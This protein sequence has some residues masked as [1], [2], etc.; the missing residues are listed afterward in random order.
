M[1][2][3]LKLQLA[4]LCS[5]NQLLAILASVILTLTP[6][7]EKVKRSPLAVV[8]GSP[9][10]FGGTVTVVGNV[11][12]AGNTTASMT[13]SGTHPVIVVGAIFQDAAITISSATWSLGSSSNS[14]IIL[15]RGGS[16]VTTAIACIVAPTTGSGT[17]TLTLSGA[18]AGNYTF[19]VDWFTGADQTTPCAGGDAVSVVT[20]SNPHTLTPANMTSNDAEWGVTGDTSDCITSVT[21][22]QTLSDCAPT[23]ASAGGYRLGTGSIVNNFS[24]ANN[25]KSSTAIR[26]KAG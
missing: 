24:Q 12:T 15:A 6:L 16:N 1:S 7:Q 5:M 21:P 9:I 17:V 8:A 14:Q 18:P 10:A 3:A 22:N 4:G 20:G 2:S 25:N 26:I 11:T 19:N 13:I 23:V